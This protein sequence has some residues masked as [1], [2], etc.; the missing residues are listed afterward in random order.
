ML[1][2]D[3]FA[4]DVTRDIPP[5]V[6]FHEQSP[7]RVRAEVD[8]YIITG[9]WPEGHANRARVPYGIHEQFRDL[10]EG[11]TTELKK[12]QGVE[13]PPAAWISG[14]YGSGKSSFA[15]LLGLALDGLE[16]EGGRPLAQALLA[17]DISPSAARL[18]SAWEG[19]QAELD[20]AVAVVF[21]I[22]G[23]ARADEHIHSAILRQV[24]RRLGYSSS[25]LVADFELRLER[26]D[27]WPAFE[28]AALEALGRPWSE[29]R[30]GTMASEDFS[31]VMAQLRPQHYTDAMSW[32]TSRAG[33]SLRGGSA[34]E[35]CRAIQ[36]ML[37]LRA[38]R[39]TLFIVVDEVSQY[40][41]QEN[42]RMLA[43]Q[44]FV[45]ELQQRLRGRAWLLVTG[46]EKLDEAGDKVVLGKMKDR[47]PSRFRVHLAQTNIRDV[48][49]RRLLRKTPEAEALLKER[50]H[51]HRQ[52]LKLYGYECANITEADFVEVYPLLPGH[53]ER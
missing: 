5:V 18:R 23:V 6:Y 37:R 31:L 30:T 51:A 1:I 47:F 33:T 14:F 22:G 41:H 25:D 24:Q 39:A 48:V 8:E 42:A 4:S 10:L 38:P 32:F 21:D 28:A 46:Q 2:R 49:H 9:G 16:L 11:I 26:E 17:R 12:P 15:K 20:E 29:C 50:F 3:L 13:L 44:S 36:D 19:L 52:D 34:E 35:C 45:S 7:A 40:I 27:E 53:L 43:L